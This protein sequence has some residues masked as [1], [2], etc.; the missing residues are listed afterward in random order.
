LKKW[1]ET[2]KKI[3]HKDEVARMKNEQKEH[4]KM[5]L[6]EIMNITGVYLLM[7]LMMQRIIN[8]DN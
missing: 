5:K 7:M 2:Q 1:K 8:F 3:M 6:D 4:S